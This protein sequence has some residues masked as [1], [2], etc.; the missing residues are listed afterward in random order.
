MQGNVVFTARFLVQRDAELLFVWCRL[1]SSGSLRKLLAGWNQLCRLA[2]RL[3]R[4]QLE[5]LDL[6]HNYLTE[7]PN[8][9]F[10]KAQRYT[11]LISSRVLSLSLIWFPFL[12]LSLFLLIWCV[13]HTLR[14]L[15]WYLITVCVTWMYQPTS[16]K[17]FL[18]LAYQRTAPAAW[19]SSMWP[20]TAWQTSV[21][22]CWQDMANSECSTLLTTSCR[23]SLQGTVKKCWKKG[24]NIVWLYCNLKWTFNPN[25]LKVTAMYNM[26]QTLCPLTG[27]ETKTLW[28]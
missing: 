11:Y 15:F 13:K 16:W 7:L 9:L 1:M 17:A 18:L 5:V 12:S 20:T 21:S 28:N 8:N 23:P 24:T 19:R 27:D 22:L 3:E 4:S 10:F 2:E 25:A 26:A 14:L 6:Q